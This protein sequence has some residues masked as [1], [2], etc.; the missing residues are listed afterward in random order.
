ME[1]FV[2]NPLLMASAVELFIEV[3][4][5]AAFC[6]IKFFAVTISSVAVA[7]SVEFV[8]L[9]TVTKI[10]L[11]V[12]SADDNVVSLL[13]VEDNVVVEPLTVVVDDVEPPATVVVVVVAVVV[14][15]SFFSSPSK[16]LAA[17]KPPAAP[18][19]P[20]NLVH[21]SN[22]I[23]LNYNSITYQQQEHHQFLSHLLHFVVVDND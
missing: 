4:F 20:P 19:R 14:V 18:A 5:N 16:A 6:G 3:E 8:E 22:Q 10:T 9:L 13:F 2:V 7:D 17:K 23:S 12:D 11:V 1:N 15:S 21:Y